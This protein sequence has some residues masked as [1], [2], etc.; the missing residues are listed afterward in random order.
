MRRSNVN[1]YSN[2]TEL[3]CFSECQLSNQLSYVWYRNGN[4]TNSDKKYFHLLTV[5]P[6]DRYKCAVE[7]D[8]TVDSPS[9]CELNHVV[10]NNNNSN[11]NN[12]KIMF[13]AGVIK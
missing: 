4:V 13:P 2:W 5:N 10:Y 7:G 8:V 9:V 12:N 11:N 6:A 1:P 3:T